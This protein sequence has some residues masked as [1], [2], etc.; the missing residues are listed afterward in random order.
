[1]STVAA[2]RMYWACHT[3]RPMPITSD[4]D[5]EWRVIEGIG[6]DANVGAEMKGVD[7]R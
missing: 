1:M 6:K 4:N 7:A 3:L 2:C 5:D